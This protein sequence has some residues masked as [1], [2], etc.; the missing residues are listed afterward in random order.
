LGFMSG[1]SG[2]VLAVTIYIKF[3]V[4]NLISPNI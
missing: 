3:I 1:S 4:A 2:C